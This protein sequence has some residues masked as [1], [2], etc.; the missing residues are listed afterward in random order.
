[1]CPTFLYLFRVTLPAVIS[2][3]VVI[4]HSV[5]QYFIEIQGFED[6]DHK[7]TDLFLGQFLGIFSQGGAVILDEVV[8]TSCGHDCMRWTSL[9][10][11]RAKIGIG[12]YRFY[13]F[14]SWF[15]RR[16]LPLKLWMFLFWTDSSF[17]WWMCSL[18]PGSR[19]RWNL[20]LLVPVLLVHSR[21]LFHFSFSLPLFFLHGA[22]IAVASRR[23]FLFA[24]CYITRSVTCVWLLNYAVNG[25]QPT[26]NQ[27]NNSFKGYG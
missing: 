26:V 9:P 15:A 16:L 3:L 5:E 6:V 21:F 17:R 27:K 22:A 24:A 8:G 7:R 23:P 18:C 14:D 4:F 12:V 20:P 11:T 2:L 13:D 1:M 25:K 10:S 19:L